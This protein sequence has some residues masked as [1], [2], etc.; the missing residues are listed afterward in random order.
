[1]N[2]EPNTPSLTTLVRSRRKHQAGPATPPR[3]QS[4]AS[5]ASPSIAHV[6]NEIRL[7]HVSDSRISEGAVHFKDCAGRCLTRR[8]HPECLLFALA[9]VGLEPPV[10]VD[11]GLTGRR[12]LRCPPDR[13]IGR[14]EVGL[15][16]P[17]RAV[18]SIL[19][20]TDAVD[21]LGLFELREG[22]LAAHP[23]LVQQ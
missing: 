18:E 23:C 17:Y 13:G 7:H 8:P 9:T 19:S 10:R 6:R 16:Q 3:R 22:F 4:P 5:G 11:E 15:G 12:G 20:V 14:R 21:P 2:T 1:L